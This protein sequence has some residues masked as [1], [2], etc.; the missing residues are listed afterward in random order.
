MTEEDINKLIA[1]EKLNDGY[2]PRIADVVR[3]LPYTS[4]NKTKWDCGV[5]TKVFPEGCLPECWITTDTGSKIME[6]CNSIIPV[7]NRTK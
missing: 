6:Y 7:L 3:P 4:S 5:V 1:E 2:I